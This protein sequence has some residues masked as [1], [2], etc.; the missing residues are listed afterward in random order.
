[1]AISLDESHAGKRNEITWRRW[2]EPG[3]RGLLELGE[4][5][6][7]RTEALAY[8][9][10]YVHSPVEKTVALRLGS[11]GAYAIWANRR[12]IARRDV[13][14][15]L[16]FDQDSVVLPLRQ[17]WNRILV[18]TCHTRG[19]WG[20]RVRLTALDGGPVDDLRVQAER[21]VDETETPAPT[22]DSAGR[23]GPGALSLLAHAAETPSTL[24]MRGWLLGRA[25]G[26]G[27]V[28]L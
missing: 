16:R 23:L 18:K 19:A 5:L 11:A 26:S 14:R 20:F 8:L 2:S 10:T 27:P 28:H 15:P 12:E 22:T 13:E 25:D 9:L 4:L 1:M 3:R 24:R 6:R 21:P 7:P 17:G